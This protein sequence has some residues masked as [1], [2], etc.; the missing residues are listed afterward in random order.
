MTEKQIDRALNLATRV[1]MAVERWIERECPE[2]DETTEATISRV[3]NSTRPQS[4]E[5]YQAFESETKSRRN[6]IA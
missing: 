5:E 4:V 1:V 3:G 6:R 2:S